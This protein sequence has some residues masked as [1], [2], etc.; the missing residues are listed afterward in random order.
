[1]TLQT[2]AQ[3]LPD[4]E[5][6][7]F[8]SHVK[9]LIQAMEFLGDPMPASEVAE[10]TNLTAASDQLSAIKSMQ[11]ILDRHVLVQV[12]INPESRVKAKPLAVKKEL[13]QQGWRNYLVKVINLAG[14]TGRLRVSSPNA[15]PLVKGSSGSP[16]P[17]SHMPAGDMV[18]RFL[19]VAMFDNPCHR[20]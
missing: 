15:R 20:P 8:A 13:M 7:P 6:Q 10:L 5:F 14:T 18:Q 11:E 9:R 19:D 1:V 3:E 4:V 17:K 2:P 12:D 16:E